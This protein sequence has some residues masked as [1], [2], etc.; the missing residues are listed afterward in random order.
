MKY[1]KKRRLN[2][3]VFFIVADPPGLEPEITESKSVVLPITPWVYINFKI[4]AQN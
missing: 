3:V 2:L 4:E 1:Y